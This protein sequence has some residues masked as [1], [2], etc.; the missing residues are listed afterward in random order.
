M[1]I[2]SIA[3]I[4][5]GFSYLKSERAIV[6]LEDGRN[7]VYLLEYSK[8]WKDIED[9]FDNVKSDFK[10]EYDDSKEFGNEDTGLFLKEELWV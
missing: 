8:S 1:N 5:E 3:M 2:K 9:Y 6:K 4:E 7:F 10:N